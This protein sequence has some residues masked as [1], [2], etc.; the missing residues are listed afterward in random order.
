MQYR[1]KSFSVDMLKSHR[2]PE[3]KMTTSQSA[4]KNFP[5]PPGLN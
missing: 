1:Q 3:A 2:R 4:H 5:E